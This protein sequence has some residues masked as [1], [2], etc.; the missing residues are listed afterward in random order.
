MGSVIKKKKT[1]E[2]CQIFT[3]TDIV[4]S[5]LDH[6]GYSRDLYG[7][8]ILENSCGDGQ[9]LKEIVNRYILDCEKRGFTPEKICDGLSRDVYGIELDPVQYKK[10]IE[11]LNALTDSHKIRR[12]SWQVKQAD[13]LRRPYSQLFDFVV[14]NPPYVSYW[15]LDLS[16]RKF[17]E[18]NFTTCTFGTWDYSYAFIQNGFNHLNPSGR[19]AYIVPNS[20]FKTKAGINVRTLLRPYITEILDYTTTKKERRTGSYQR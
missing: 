12:V 17:V 7:K 10:C 8:S 13:A 20:I 18:K 14:G 11:G 5:M 6:L 3:P 15:D 4:K 9:F 2:K 1:R 16:E 19:M